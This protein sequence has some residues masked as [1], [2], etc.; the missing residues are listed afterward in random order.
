MAYTF[1]GSDRCRQTR[2][3]DR[4]RSSKVSRFWTL[5]MNRRLGRGERMR[6][7]V[8]TGKLVRG[9]V[10]TVKT[11]WERAWVDGKRRPVR[12]SEPAQYSIVETIVERLA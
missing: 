5:V 7:D 10:T 6:F 1:G 4:L 11:S 2:E 3:S 8:L 12:L 9:S